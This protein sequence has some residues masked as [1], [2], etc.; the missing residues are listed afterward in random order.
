[1]PN[2]QERGRRVTAAL[3]FTFAER[4]AQV[5]MIFLPTLRSLIGPLPPGVLAARFFAAVMRPP[6]L[7]LAIWKSPSRRAFSYWKG[8]SVEGSTFR[9]VTQ[10]TIAC[11]DGSRGVAG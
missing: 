6:L 4:V 5:F 8:P 2:E 11:D 3:L 10:N 1:M 7:A 9:G